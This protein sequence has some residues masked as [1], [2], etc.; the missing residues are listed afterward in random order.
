MAQRKKS[1]STSNTSGRS[2]AE[3]REQYSANAERAKVNYAKA[4]DAVSKTLRD[5]S[6]SSTKTI[7]SYDKD[8]IRGYLTGNIANNE[9]NLRAASRYLYYRSHIYFR[10]CHFYAD[11]LCLD[12]R[13]VIP[14]YSLTKANNS[15]S[16]LKQYSETLDF[17]DVMNLQRNMSE[18]LLNCWIDDVCYALYFY[19][20]T[21]SFFYILDADECKIDSRYM[22]GDFGFSIDM[23]KWRSS[24]RRQYIEWLGE[25]LSSMWNE[26]QSSGSKWV[27]VPDEYAAVFKQRT[28]DWETVIPPFITLMSQLA[29]LND[30]VDVQAI[31]DEQQI[32]KLVY[33]PMKVLSGSK[34]SDDFE[35]SPDIML[36]YFDKLVDEALPDYISAT[37][38][39]GDQLGVIDFSDNASTDVN[40]VEKSQSQILATAGGGFVLDSSKITSTAAFNAALKAETEFAISSFLPQIEGFT[41]RMLSYNVSN[42]CKVEYFPV[43]VYTKDDLRKSLLESCQYSFA[44]R[45]AYNTFL[46]ISQKETLS[47]LYLENEVL[48]L[49][50]SMNFPLSSSF[51]TSNTGEV[52]RGRET[53]P[54]DELSISGDRSRNQ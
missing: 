39:P 41:N 10:I 17:L 37:P 30:L 8:T 51:T 43:S 29:N 25:P 19:D 47:M 15:S 45:L 7:T 33:L 9:K 24:T 54:D 52:G 18:V 20:E 16:I 28:D 3:I 11:M 27:H 42:P 53:L 1:T 23:S 46:G 44:N 4:L 6:K 22:T 26:Y 2:V 14:N 36:K 34:V 21:G 13:K 12:C 5:A 35:I 48:G 31:A 32:Y 49:P 40:R 38:I 50:S